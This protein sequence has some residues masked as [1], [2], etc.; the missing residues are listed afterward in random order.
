MSVTTSELNPDEPKSV[1]EHR[2]MLSEPQEEATQEET[3]EE[4]VEEVE[5]QAETEIEDEEYAEEEATLPDGPEENL[6][7]VK[8]D[9][10]EKEVTVEELKRGYSGQ[11]YIQ[12]K[13]RE[14][15][16]ARKQVESQI[17]QAQQMEQRYSEAMKAY[18]ERLQT[19]EPT[20]PDIKMRETDPLGYLEQ[21]EDYRQEVEARQ[22]LQYEQHVQAQR[23]QQLA[24]QQKAEYVKAQTQ[25]VL[26]QIPELRDKEAA[27]KAIEMM[28]EEGRR[29]GFSDVELKG[30]SDPRFVM[31]LHELAK[32]RAQGNLGTGRE[33]K[34]GAIKPGAKK[35]IVSQSRKRAEAARQQSR[36]TGKTED[37]AA[38]LLTKD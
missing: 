13:M 24:H 38:F 5:A 2:L 9:G 28:M 8:I 37:I 34:R 26:E 18:S 23:E 33:V 27:P 29:R 14:V 22:K 30:E 32:V 25:V 7:S 35:S 6:F 4:I 17:V 15:A 1:A 16:D 10:V 21:M 12:Q 19:T 31:A 11:K 20:A 3:S 36:K